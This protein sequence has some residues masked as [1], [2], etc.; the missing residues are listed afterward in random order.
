MI[1]RCLS[2]A[3]FTA[4]LVAVEP[5]APALVTLLRQTQ[6]APPAAAVARLEVWDG[7]DHPLRHLALGLLRLRLAE[8]P[9]ADAV[10]LLRGA[11][12][13]FTDALAGD[14]TLR[15]AHLGLARCAAHRED[16]P[17]ARRHAAAAIDP[18]TAEAAH[19]VFLAETARRAGDHRLATLAAQTGVLR[20]P[21]DDRLRR[22]ELAALVEAGRAEDARQA[23]LALLAQTPTDTALWRHLAWA[24]QT[25]HRPDE[26]L[27]ALEAALATAPGDTLLRRQVGE[28][29][30]AQGLASAALAT[31]TPLVDP[32][33]S[34]PDLLLMVARAAADA[35]A[36]PQAR[37][38]LAQVPRDR[39]TRDLD[40]Q[41]A[42][43]AVLAGDAN[44]AAAALDRLIAAGESD[45]GI[46][47]WAGVLAEQRG[48][49]ARAEALLRIAASA[50]EHP[51][52]AILRL[53]ALM[54]G[55]GRR[56]E[57]HRFITSHLERRPED[58]Q[59]RVLQR[60]LEE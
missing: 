28:Y 34:P 47:T 33:T 20:F 49:A 23:V 8:A 48:D 51:S 7:P 3:L 9:G 14:D 31:L 11:E 50:P 40:I 10:A 27:A 5:P 46:L 55:Q 16:W 4:A 43:L 53:A 17:A 25:T 15:Q 1:P 12:A 32:A 26:A 2:L 54:L 57:A 37:A 36:I 59:A 6:E 29:F 38:W 24:A 45:S 39:R 58:T 56:E 60:Y 19:L 44:V 13:A 18:G 42:R 22:L 35:E 30:L 21:E 52:A 41:E